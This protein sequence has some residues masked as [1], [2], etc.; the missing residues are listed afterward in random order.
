MGDEAFDRVFGSRAIQLS[1]VIL[2]GGLGAMLVWVV[3]TW[4]AYRELTGMGRFRSLLAFLLFCVICVPV[5]IL[6][7]LIAAALIS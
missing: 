3:V 5:Y 2:L 1:T 7:T 4:G 6:T